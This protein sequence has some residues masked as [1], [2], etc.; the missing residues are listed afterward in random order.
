MKELIKY[1]FRFL[2][3][4]LKTQ[5]VII[6]KTNEKEL[7]FTKPKRKVDRV[8]IHCS[9][10]D[11]PKHDVNEI[12]KWHLLRNFKDVGYSYIITKSG[13]IQKGRSLE[14]IPASQ[15][16]YNRH[17]ISICVCGLSEF[18]E[19]SLKRLRL[20]CQI[21]NRNYEDIKFHGHCEISSKTCP[22]FNYRKLLNLSKSGEMINSK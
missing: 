14:K 13:E 15:K 8:F 22:V 1:I 9:A 5:K 18:T 7:L 17:S 21:I 6:K 4:S 10:S 12:R 16:G 11:N 2:M 19:I 20:L 3:T